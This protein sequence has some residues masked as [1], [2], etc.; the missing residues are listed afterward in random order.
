MAKK[1][2]GDDDGPTWEEAQELLEHDLDEL[3]RFKRP[4][5]GIVR[6]LILLILELRDTRTEVVKAIRALKPKTEKA[7]ATKKATT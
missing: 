5:A 1:K 3:N 4:Q 7:K 2:R 6:A